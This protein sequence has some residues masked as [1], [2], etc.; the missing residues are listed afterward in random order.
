MDT[1]IWE[2]I[3]G[4]KYWDVHA[5]NYTAQYF[6]VLWERWKNISQKCY[7]KH[8]IY[9]KWDYTKWC[10]TYILQNLDP[11]LWGNGPFTLHVKGPA[12]LYCLQ[13]WKW[14][15]RMVS[16]LYSPKFGPPF[17]EVMGHIPFVRVGPHDCA[18]I[19][20]QDLLISGF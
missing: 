19:R 20:L 8:K 17:Y 3:K 12:R 1:F 16:N 7:T 18:T 15:Y 2:K 5:H 13:D 10:L 9:W 6:T 4:D 11:F 14:D